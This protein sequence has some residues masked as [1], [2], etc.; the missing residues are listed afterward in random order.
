MG[1]IARGVL[2]D[3]VRPVCDTLPSHPCPCT[4]RLPVS[5]FHLGKCPSTCY[6]ADCDYWVAQ[7]S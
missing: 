3:Q 2:A 4:P 7:G 6:G 1:V 5:L